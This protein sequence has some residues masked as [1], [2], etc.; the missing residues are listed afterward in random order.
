MK[1]QLVS[2][3][4]IPGNDPG[5][6]APLLHKWFARRRPEAV[7][8]I[9]DRLEMLLE[10]PSLQIY[11][12]FMG[13]GMLLLEAALRGH[14]V[15]GVDVNPVAW[16]I[17][18]QSL[19]PIPYDR[20]LKALRDVQFQVAETISSIYKTINQ[21][22]EV[23]DSVTAFYVRVMSD[24]SGHDMELHHNYLLA[25]NRSA[26]WAVYYCPVC[27]SVFTS[28]CDYRVTC[29]F[30]GNDFAWSEGNV[31]R[32]QAHCGICEESHELKP[33]Y[34]NERSSP[35]FKMIAVESFSESYG[36]LFH[37]PSEL[38]HENTTLAAKSCAH[39]PFA[40]SIRSVQIPSQ[41]RDPRPISHGFKYYG[42]L[43][44]PRQLFCLGLIAEAISQVK[45][46]EERFALAL[47][48]SDAAGS[49]NL[50]C[51]YAADWLK[52]TPAFG[53]HGFDVVTRPV[54]GNVWGAGRGRG[55]FR[56][57]V[58]KAAKAYSAIDRAFRSSSTV[59]HNR[60]LICASAQDSSGF[61][62]RKVDAV[63][64]DPPYFDNI[65][66]AEL[67]DF[68]YQWLRLVLKQAPQFKPSHCFSEDDL[69]TL[70]TNTDGGSRFWRELAV[71]FKTSL[72]R[73]SKGGIVAFTYHHS[74]RPAWLALRNAL[75]T[76]RLTTFELGFVRSE[77]DNGFHSAEGNIKVDAI[78][79][80]RKR[81][82]VNGHDIE[83]MIKNAVH[84]LE[85]LQNLK[86]ID[87]TSAKLAIATALSS[88]ETGKS[89]DDLVQIAAK[90]VDGQRI[91]LPEK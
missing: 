9:L 60:D 18:R 34:R 51:R 56:N 27:H 79:Y 77:L 23:V 70:A 7:N 90:Y 61:D 49:N 89:F 66:Y 1:A 62:D 65:D 11:D 25:R 55:S 53:L 68:Y 75:N 74:R 71:C 59:N 30:C 57:C 42:D 50:M 31:S 19:N 15:Y 8:S 80:C 41:R 10:K 78:F 12:P 6:L 54:E 4:L 38:D 13:S 83:R 63:L 58:M 76:C 45:G 26:N 3:N 64:T 87:L 37:T 20:L 28:N 21:E 72:R 14:N 33:L 52:L 85:N 73:L 67:A 29:S 84:Q 40:V 82:S 35:R 44:T 86:T 81:D 32:G 2:S 17:A 5:R 91:V 69:S 36:R 22:G 46:E 16:L 43:F 24:N 47:A 39:N 88:V 48:L